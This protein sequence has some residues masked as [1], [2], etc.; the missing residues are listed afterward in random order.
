MIKKLQKKDDSK[1]ES[2]HS[3][4][5]EFLPQ[6]DSHLSSGSSKFMSYM[7][8]KKGKDSG[9]VNNYVTNNIGVF[10]GN[11]G[12]PNYTIPVKPSEVTSLDCSSSLTHD[13]KKMVLNSQKS[14]NNSSVEMRSERFLKESLSQNPVPT[15]GY[16]DYSNTGNYMIPNK[17]YYGQ[18]YPNQF[19]NETSQTPNSYVNTPEAYYPQYQ[20][21]PQPEAT[22]YVS[23]GIPSNYTYSVPSQQAYCNYPQGYNNNTG[24]N[25]LNG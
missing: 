14:T 9:V 3:S 23:Y 21:R 7:T 11:P 12:A 5:Q 8:E 17:A 24:Y 19:Y 2:L 10:I 25:Y 16:K 18:Q 6:E 13:A 15:S 4:L 20:S 22:P 1:L